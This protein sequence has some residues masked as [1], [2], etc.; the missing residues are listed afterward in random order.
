MFAGSQSFGNGGGPRKKK[1]MPGTGTAMPRGG[2]QPT[3]APPMA[4]SGGPAPMPSPMGGPPPMGGDGIV[5]PGGGGLERDTT[6]GYRPPNG[7]TGIS[8]MMDPTNWPGGELGLDD[9]P[10]MMQLQM[11]LARLAGGRS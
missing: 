2:V 9:N 6:N 5:P 10:L 3:T 1:P 8:G 7:N 4:P 11:L